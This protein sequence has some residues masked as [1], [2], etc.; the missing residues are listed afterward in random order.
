MHSVEASGTCDSVLS[1]DEKDKGIKKTNHTRKSSYMCSFCD[2]ST[3]KSKSLKAHMLKHRGEELTSFKCDLCDFKSMKHENL[4]RHDAEHTMDKLSKICDDKSKVLTVHEKFPE[5]FLDEEVDKPVLNDDSPTEHKLLKR[6]RRESGNEKPDKHELYDN[7]MPRIGEMDDDAL[8]PVGKSFQLSDSAESEAQKQDSLITMGYLDGMKDDIKPNQRN[9]E[10]SK[11]SLSI[12]VEKHKSTH[13]KNGMKDDIK[14]NQRNPEKYSKYSQSIPVEKHKS[15]HTKKKRFPCEVCKK[16]F[17]F[18]ESLREHF[19][20]HTGEKP[21]ACKMCDFKAARSNIL[22][23]HMITHREDNPFK[24]D[25]CGFNAAFKL[26]LNRHKA[27]E[28]AGIGGHLQGLGGKPAGIGGPPYKCNLCDFVAETYGHFSLHVMTHTGEKPYKCDVCNYST[29]WPSTFKRHKMKHTGEKRFQCNVCGFTCIQSAHFK[30]H[31][32]KH[33]GEKP[34]MC[35]WCAYT[36]SSL[37]CLKTHVLKHTSEKL[38]LCDVC[39][40][41]SSRSSNLKAH[42]KTQHKV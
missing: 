27:T 34:Y 8:T 38:F 14:P 16:M 32:K 3:R 30:S 42:M 40:Y 33:T 11:C 6:V 37:A 1:Q 2:Y 39:G 13:T 9:P 4:I 41:K 25:I 15:T 24:C 21:Y 12:P 23:R 31:M 35:E 29:V 28:H 7:K 10:N 36:S 5:K 17:S 19:R 22:K 18:R 20:R 26:E